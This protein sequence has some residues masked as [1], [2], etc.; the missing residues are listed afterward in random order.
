MANQK[1]KDFYALLHQKRD[2]PKVQIIT[3]QRSIAKYGG[4]RMYIAPPLAYDELMKEVPS[5]KVITVEMIRDHLAKENDADFTDPVTAASFVNIVAWASVQNQTD[6]TPFWRTLKAD[7]ELNDKYPGGIIVQ[8][9]KLEAEGHTVIR[10][11]IKH[12]RFFVENYE[13]V[14]WEIG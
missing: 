6:Q 1:Q 5:G 12:I 2:M 8:K 13:S 9:E 14:L 7:G 3:D 10:R 4:D 11:G